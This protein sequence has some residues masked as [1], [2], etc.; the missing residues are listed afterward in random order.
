M[1]SLELRINNGLVGNAYCVNEFVTEEGIGVY[2]IEYYRVGREPS[3]IK[4]KIAHKREEDAEKLALLILQEVDKRL[5][6]RDVS[7]K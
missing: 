7:K 5:K 3:V 6:K 4:F 2:N 1:F